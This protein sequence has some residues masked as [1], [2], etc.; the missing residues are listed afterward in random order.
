MPLSIGDKL[1]P[2]EI[3]APIGKGGMGEV[4]KARD[5]KLKRD[6]A[7]KVLPE[8]FARDR[9]R[10]ARFQR[11]AEVLASLNHPNIAAIYGVEERALVMELAEGASPKGPLPF[12]EAWKIASQIASALAY[13]HDKGIMHRDLKPANI[14]VTPEGLVKLL[15]FGLAKAFTNRG[16]APASAGSSPEN[17]PTLTLGATEVGMILGTAAYMAPEQARGKV[18]DKRAD[19]WSFGVVLYELLTGERLFFGEDAAETLAAVIHKQPDFAKAPRQARRLLEECLQKDSKQR[20]R[21]IGDAKRLLGEEQ[22]AQSPPAPRHRS[23]LP[24]CIAA[25][26]LLVLMPANI[27]HFRETHPVEQS[28]RYQIP[29][30]G[31]AAAQY[32]ALSPD[33]RNLAFVANNGGP[34]QVWVRAMDTLEARALAGTDGATYPFWSPDGAYVGFFTDGKL[35]KIAVAGGPPQTLCDAASGRGGTWNRAG[36]I[37]FSPGPASVI[38]RV[39]AAGGAPV[40]VT[41]LSGNGAGEGNRFPVFLPDGDHFVYNVGSDRPDAAGVFVGSLEGGA[42]ARLLPDVSNALYAPPAVAGSAAYL[43]FRRENTLLAQPFD[44]KGLKTT[45]DA[46]PIAEQVPGGGNNGFGAFSISENG[47][48]VYRSGGAA[49]NRELVWMDRTG[50]RLGTLGKPG[51]FVGFNV[52]PDEKT[53][54]V[55]I[56]SGAQADIWLEDMARSVLSRFTFRS[57]IATNAIWSP[58]GSRLVFSIQTLGTYSSDIYQKPAGGNGQ[59]ELLLHSGINGFPEDWS[60]D[61]QWIAYRKTGEKTALDLWLLPLNGDRKPVPYLQSPFDETNARFSPDGKWMAYQ[62]NESGRFQI[63]VQTVPPSGAK[64][65]ISSSGGTAPHWGRD[66][67]EL[68]Y[69]S[70]DL[71][72]MAVPIKLGATVEVGTPQPLFPIPQTGAGFAYAPM[73]DGQRFL[74]NAPAGGETAAVQPIT[75]VTNWQAGLKK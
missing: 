9:E 29:P 3:L 40:P 48:L 59:E 22:P 70:A 17:S 7:L 67:K 74:V 58:D 1:G 35:K 23:W 50:K 56:G 18:V 54:A 42:P 20:L 47:M 26:F 19:I 30:P 52:S 45:G 73:G 44:A 46:F 63:Y 51:D 75:V 21:D 38:F 32:L 60:P 66:R 53:L 24:W 16:D 27:L 25:F 41:K 11:E 14:M 65:Q 12:E 6:V 15:D 34:N 57:G 61:G 49:A 71:K 43:L 8:A 33:G 69:V 72:L 4:W 37:L 55:R 5:T 2:Y 28:L 13:A 62:S 68:F 64:Y 31:T 39:P 10:M 36:V